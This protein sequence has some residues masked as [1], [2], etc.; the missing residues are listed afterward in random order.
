MAPSAVPSITE[1]V[2][3]LVNTGISHTMI[4]TTAS[5]ALNSQPSKLKEL[6]A[7]RL[8]FTRNLNPHSVP[9]PNS[10]EVWAQNVYE[11][12]VTRFSSYL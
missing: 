6:D 3:E 9:K 12:L 7:A 8:V 10:P 2:P 5:T 1:T 4:N 11:R